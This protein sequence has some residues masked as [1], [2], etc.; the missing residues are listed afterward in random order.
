M[1]QSRRAPL[2]YAAAAA[3]AALLCELPVGAVAHGGY[4]HVSNTS[5]AWQR[6]NIALNN[7]GYAEDGYEGLDTSVEWHV[8][9]RLRLP[10]PR[11]GWSACR[12]ARAG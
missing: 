6:A 2:P 5:A 7:G 9:V 8:Q 4:H 1:L 12:A 10:T 11:C 3:A